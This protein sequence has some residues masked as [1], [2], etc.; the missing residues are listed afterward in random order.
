MDKPTARSALKPR[1]PLLSKEG[2]TGAK[3]R[4]GGSAATPPRLR[5]PPR[6]GVG[7]R[8][9]KSR[10]DKRQGSKGQWTVPSP[11][12]RAAPHKNSPPS[13]GG[14]DRSEA[15]VGWFRGD[16]EKPPHHLHT[17]L[18][19]PSPRSPLRRAAPPPLAA[20]P[21][22]QPK[23]PRVRSTPRGAQATPARSAIAT[24]DHQTT[25]TSPLD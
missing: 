25:L 2:G 10:E 21:S 6:S 1:I 5:T 13:Q 19:P 18:R 23:A 15:T 12:R 17:A 24:P 7:N 3:Q 9:V 20:R 22:E 4:W 11:R 8:R 14:G 16:T